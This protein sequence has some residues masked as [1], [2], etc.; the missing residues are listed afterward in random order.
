MGNWVPQCCDVCD[1]IAHDLFQLILVK[2]ASLLLFNWLEVILK[3]AIHNFE[4]FFYLKL[5]F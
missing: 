1:V 4:P 5:F 2:S 3:T